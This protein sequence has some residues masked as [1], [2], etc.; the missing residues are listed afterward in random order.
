MLGVG[1]NKNSSRSI[2]ISEHL[3]MWD[4]PTKKDDIKNLY[5]VEQYSIFLFNLPATSFDELKMRK[6]T[7]VYFNIIQFPFKVELKQTL[8]IIPLGT[9]NTRYRAETKWPP[10]ISEGKHPVYVL[11]S[12]YQHYAMGSFSKYVPFSTNTKLFIPL[13]KKSLYIHL[14]FASSHS[15]RSRIWKKQGSHFKIKSKIVLNSNFTWLFWFHQMLMRRSADQWWNYEIFIT[16]INWNWIIQN[17]TDEPDKLNQIKLDF[18]Q[19]SIYS[20]WEKNKTKLLW[21]YLRGQQEKEE[22]LKTHCFHREVASHIVVRVSQ[23]VSRWDTS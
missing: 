1:S 3:K 7:T 15:I 20:R 8:W 23:C 2:D 13:L 22:A 11:L 17:V 18:V 14:R 16:V 12:A 6:I 21:E 10:T 4:S 9:I 5:Y 19:L